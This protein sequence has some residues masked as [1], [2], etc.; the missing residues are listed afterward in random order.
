[1]AGNTQSDAFT[2]NVCNLEITSTA[3]KPNARY[4]KVK[5]EAIGTLPEWH[6]GSDDNGWLFVDEV[7]IN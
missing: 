1:M 3:R 7:I 5:A 4:I 6:P 2:Q